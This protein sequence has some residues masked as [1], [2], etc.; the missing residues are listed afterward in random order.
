[1]IGHRKPHVASGAPSCSDSI[2]RSDPQTHRDYGCSGIWEDGMA[3]CFAHL[4]SALSAIQELSLHP[5]SSLSD[6]YFYD[7]AAGSVCVALVALDACAA[8]QVPYQA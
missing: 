8:T 6:A 5:G 7:Q 4:R 1:M 2:R 3:T